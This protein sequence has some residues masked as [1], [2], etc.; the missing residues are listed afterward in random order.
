MY[1]PTEGGLAAEHGTEAVA[2]NRPRPPLQEPR[3]Q[4]E[5]LLPQYQPEAAARA[6]GI[7]ERRIA[8]QRSAVAR[9]LVE[10]KHLPRSERD[11]TRAEKA[12]D[13]MRVRLANALAAREVLQSGAENG[14]VEDG[15][16]DVLA[17]A[18]ATALEEQG[19][20]AFEGGFDCR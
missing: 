5:A 19:L 17:G 1:L 6:L 4:E 18:L 3:W 8:D 14:E 2:A 12:L 11:A 20:R 10:L 16:S 9:L 13:E 7:L 15:I